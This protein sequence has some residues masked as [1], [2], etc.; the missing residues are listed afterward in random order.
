MFIVRQHRSS[1]AV[2]LQLRTP[3]N[4]SSSSE[5][6]N[7]STNFDRDRNPIRSNGFGSVTIPNPA[8]IFVRGLDRVTA[9]IYFIRHAA[10]GHIGNTLSGRQP[11]IPLTDAG[12]GQ[13]RALGARLADRPFAALHSSPV[14]R[15]RETADAVREVRGGEN[16]QVYTA[17]DE[18]DFGAWTGKAFA[19]LEDDPQWQH[20]NARR[21]EARCPGGEAMAEVQ[22]RV[23]AHAEQAAAAHPDGAVA[24]VT[25][26]DIIRA[27]V[28]H[29]L[30]LSLD[31]IHSF[32]IDPASVS[33]VAVGDWGGRVLSLNEQVA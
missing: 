25:H 13:A 8:G 16:V 15:A 24:M 32:D 11:A 33:R 10:H 3:F 9:T 2:Q 27:A 7:G 1:L 14:Q 12:R 19:D 6:P 17:L 20:W 18:I 23:V 30:G 31:R 21:S 26:C 29:W 4:A 28:A 5:F 22:A